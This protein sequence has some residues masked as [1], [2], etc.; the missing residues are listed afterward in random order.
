M[1]LIIFEAHGQF[2]I[3]EFREYGECLKQADIWK[4]ELKNSYPD[5]KPKITYYYFL[6]KVQG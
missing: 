1:W 3:R 4:D 6:K 5:Y 2:K